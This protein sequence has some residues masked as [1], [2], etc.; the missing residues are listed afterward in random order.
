[1]PKTKHPKT[2][3]KEEGKPLQALF[4]TTGINEEKGTQQA[5]QTQTLRAEDGTSLGSHGEIRGFAK[6]MANHG[7]FAVPGR[8]FKSSADALGDCGLITRQVASHQTDKLLG[9]NVI[10]E[11]KYGVDLTGKVIGVSI[12]AEGCNIVSNR[13]VLQVDCRDPRIQKGLSDLQVIDFINGETDRHAGNIFIDPRTG[14]VTG[15]DNDLS[16]PEKAVGGQA[17]DKMVGMPKVI[18]EDTKKRILETKPEDLRK[19]LSAPPPKNGPKPLSKAAIDGAVNRLTA[20]Q[21]E[22]GKKEGSAIK[23]VKAFDD[24]TYK[25]AIDEANR[26]FL[27]MQQTN[28]STN[29][30][31]T[32]KRMDEFA[33]MSPAELAKVPSSAIKSVDETPKTSYLATVELEM[34]KNRMRTGPDKLPEH[35]NAL[36]IARVPQIAYEKTLQEGYAKMSKND[37]KAFDK[38]FARLNKMEEQLDSKREHLKHPGITDR[39][40][41]VVIGTI[42]VLHEKEQHAKLLEKEIQDL[43]ETLKQRAES[44]LAVGTGQTIAI[45]SVS[46]A[47]EDLPRQQLIEKPSLEHGHSVRQDL[48]GNQGAPRTALGPKTKLDDGHH[49]VAQDTGLTV[50]HEKA[51]TEKRLKVS[52]DLANPTAVLCLNRPLHRE[53]RVRCGTQIPRSPKTREVVHLGG[54]DVPIGH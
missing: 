19:K 18:H 7:D 40:K 13:G 12:Q 22:L 5:S 50:S 35:T 54:I 33:R 49:S 46:N 27:G 14:K 26:S 51:K 37:Q 44:T 47:K 11:E 34:T 4:F 32:P 3:A 43:K 15:I 28:M 8:L 24:G 10:A 42:P 48:E 41:S 25:S 17:V 6:S 23:V 16:F 36:P 39:L 21:E 20:L 30:Q 45:D 38:D 31:Y 1:M 2:V 29:A 53:E 52:L 9:L